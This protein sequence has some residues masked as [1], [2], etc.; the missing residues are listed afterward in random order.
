MQVLS[1][2]SEVILFGDLAPLISVVS[3]VVAVNTAFQKQSPSAVS[4]SA[5]FSVRQVSVTNS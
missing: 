3:L 4:N 5:K 2:L 1:P